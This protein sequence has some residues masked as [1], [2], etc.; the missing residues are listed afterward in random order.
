MGYTNQM[1]DLQT[2]FDRAH[3]DLQRQ[4]AFA[5]IGLIL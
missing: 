2:A 3:M 1:A 5:A 4:A